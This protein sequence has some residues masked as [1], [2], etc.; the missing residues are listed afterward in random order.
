MESYVRRVVSSFFNEPATSIIPIVGKGSVNHIFLVETLDSRVIVRL[1]NDPRSLQ[2]YQKESWCLTQA[3][4]KGIPSPK[5]LT[6]GTVDEYAYMI[7]SFV[8]GEHGE[9]DSVDR[10]FVWRTLGEYVNKIGAIKVIGYGENLYDPL[11]GRFEAPR[12]EG[13]DGT[14]SGYLSYNINS[15][16]NE[17]RLI[18]LGV[19][20]NAQSKSVRNLF[21]KLYDYEF[22]IGLNHGDISLK[23]TIIGTDGRVHLLDWGSAEVTLTPFWDIIQVLRCH[24]TEDNPTRDEYVAFLEGLGMSQDWYREQEILINT[25]LLLRAFDKLRW[26]IDRSQSHVPEF[27]VYARR[28]LQRVLR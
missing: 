18:N 12:F 1:N 4:Q 17:D 20:T 21:E 14:W 10:Y 28:V 27:S 9:S 26:A 5:V 6:L 22:T 19:L 15:L 8:D 24:L 16:T 3:A 2:D 23:N 13:F 11:I 25:L 7:Q